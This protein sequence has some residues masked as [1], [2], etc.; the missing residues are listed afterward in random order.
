VR[1]YYRKPVVG[2][3]R[4]V[5]AEPDLP[6]LFRVVVV[7]HLERRITGD[8][9][10]FFQQLGIARRHEA[11]RLEEFPEHRERVGRLDAITLLPRLEVPALELPTVLALVAPIIVRRWRECAA[12]KRANEKP[13]VGPK[14]NDGR[15]RWRPV[16]R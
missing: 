14:P 11:H 2:V 1:G 10:E 12:A 5:G 7:M 8:G 6:P 4:F 16:S 15:I 3:L 13:A 9:L